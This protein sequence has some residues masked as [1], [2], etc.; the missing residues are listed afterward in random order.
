MKEGNE[1]R[2]SAPPTRQAWRLMAWIGVTALMMRMGVKWM[3]DQERRQPTE[4]VD[5]QAALATARRMLP[6]AHQPPQRNYQELADAVAPQVAALMRCDIPSGA[7]RV[8]AVD[9]YDWLRAN[10]RSFARIMAPLEPHWQSAHD[11]TDWGLAG[12]R[13]NGRVAGVQ[14]G[15]LLGWMATRVLGQYDV[16]IM[17]DADQPNELLLVDTNITR[18]AGEQRVDA[19][20]MREWI[21]I[22]EV[23][24][25]FQ[26]EGIPWL[27]PKMRGLMEAFMQTLAAQM[28]DD[29]GGMWALAQRALQRGGQGNWLEWAMTDAQQ[30]LFAEMQVMM[31]LI[32]GHSN[33][34][35]NT[36]GATRIPQFQRLH[37][38]MEA[39]QHD[40]PTFDALILRVT[41]MQV[42]MAQY[43]DGERFVQAVARHGGPELVAWM[44]RDEA[45][46]PTKEE[47]HDP[48][49][50]LAR[51]APPAGATTV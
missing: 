29:T 16:A 14:S 35:M 25:V 24:H 47:L 45:H 33:Y 39:R 15:A 2:R 42:K 21:V 20:A 48:A 38:R 49:R 41:G 37:Q 7:L 5:W 22:H 27:K 11:D 51:H 3:A 30:R 10:L 23:S 36:I 40:R 12:R 6:P 17:H 13:L 4:M 28:A 8:R 46:L 26:F 19:A 32:E 44:W 50:W 34:V 1:M 31:S 9:Q 43:R 18:I